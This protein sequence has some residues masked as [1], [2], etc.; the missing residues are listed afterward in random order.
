ME[1]PDERMRRQDE[2]Q[3]ERRPRFPAS[4]ATTGSKEAPRTAP[5]DS[6]IAEAGQRIVEV[7]ASEKRLMNRDAWGA[8]NLSKK[9]DLFNELNNRIAEQTGQPPLKGDIAGAEDRL[10]VGGRK[11]MAFITRENSRHATS[12]AYSIAK[13]NAYHFEEQLFHSDQRFAETRE[14]QQISKTL[15]LSGNRGT[16]RTYFATL[17]TSQIAG[18]AERAIKTGKLIRPPSPPEKMVEDKNKEPDHLPSMDDRRLEIINILFSDSRITDSKQWEAMKDRTAD[19]H[20]LFADLNAKIAASQGRDALMAQFGGRKVTLYESKGERA[21]QMPYEM[22]ESRLNF[23]TA[24]GQ[25]NLRE[26]QEC[27]RENPERFPEVVANAKVKHRNGEERDL[28]RVNYEEVR[29]DKL[30]RERQ[31]TRRIS[32]HTLETIVLSRE[33]LSAYGDL[34]AREA[35]NQR[36]HLQ[37]LETKRQKLQTEPS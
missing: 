1:V 34:K 35:E 22:A 8:M 16:E 36:R 12:F 19:K 13:L 23:I 31:G 24:V 21:A 26:F 2:R 10:E 17:Q 14:G 20:H 32:V 18:E 4:D 30:R 27:H 11:A 33:I 25:L 29:R 9:R 5:Y 37:Q 7:L 28:G 3:H 15:S 6:R